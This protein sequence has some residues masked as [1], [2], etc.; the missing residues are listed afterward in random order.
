MLNSSPS[1]TRLTWCL[2][3]VLPQPQSY[4]RSVDLQASLESYFLSGLTY[5]YLLFTLQSCLTV[6]ALHLEYFKQAGYEICLKASVVSLVFFPLWETGRCPLMFYYLQ[7]VLLIKLSTRETVKIEISKKLKQDEFGVFFS[8]CVRHSLLAAKIPQFH[9][10][11]VAKDL[12]ERW[13]KK[14]LKVF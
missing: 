12:S 1:N 8:F 7:N 5:F 9:S 2:W 14:S 6:A 13:N 3:L 11:M 10:T 4:Y